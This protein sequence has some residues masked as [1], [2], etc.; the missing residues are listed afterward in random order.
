MSML[1]HRFSNE[2]WRGGAL[3]HLPLLFCKS[4]YLFVT[5]FNSPCWFLLNRYVLPFYFENLFISFYSVNISNWSA[6]LQRIQK[7]LS[8]VNQVARDIQSPSNAIHYETHCTPSRL[9]LPATNIRI[10]FSPLLTPWKCVLRYLL[11]KKQTKISLI[12]WLD[13]ESDK[14]SFSLI[15]KKVPKRWYRNRLLHLY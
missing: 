5:I 14:W 11:I 2:R 15:V 12:Y 8:F 6:C 4:V 1:R 10:T 9:I 13:I 7:Q 3:K